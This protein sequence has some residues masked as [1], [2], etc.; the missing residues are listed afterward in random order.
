[1]NLVSPRKVPQPAA[2]VLRRL[3]TSVCSVEIISIIEPMGLRCL[4]WVQEEMYSNLV[5]HGH[6]LKPLLNG[7]III[8]LP[9]TKI[10]QKL[11]SD[12]TL[13]VFEVNTVLV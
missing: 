11:S 1:M 7:R 2:R 5:M 6:C 13:E 9:S 8:I 3:P 10:Y 4:A 12:M